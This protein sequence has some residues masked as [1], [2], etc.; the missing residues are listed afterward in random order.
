MNL[1]FTETYSFYQALNIPEISSSFL[2]NLGDMRI[3]VTQIKRIHSFEFN[4]V[5][6]Y[7]ICHKNTCYKMRAVTRLYV[8]S[9]TL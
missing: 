3:F 5:L 1:N 4:W 7:I 9:S 2:K 8:N 6:D